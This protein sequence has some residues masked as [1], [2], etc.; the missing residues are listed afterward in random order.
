ME[1]ER[2]RKGA[3]SPAPVFLPPSS[4]ASSSLLF[5]SRIPAHLFHFPFSFIYLV[6]H[7]LMRNRAVLSRR[8]Q[9]C[10]GG[11][12]LDSCSWLNE[13]LWMTG[14]CPVSSFPQH[15]TSCSRRKFYL[16]SSNTHMLWN[17]PV[18]IPF[19]LSAELL[20]LPLWCSL[21][22]EKLMLTSCGHFQDSQIADKQ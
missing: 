22:Q 15:C 4:A 18:A 10:F 5:C 14:H 20:S 11:T 17:P 12:C 3:M 16:F 21:V 7:I 6:I 9:V 19:S 2:L 8:G 1:S 13:P